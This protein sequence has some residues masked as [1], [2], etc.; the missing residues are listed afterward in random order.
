MAWGGPTK[1]SRTQAAGLQ[2][3]RQKERQ[4]EPEQT[5]S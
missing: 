5:L 4:A 2:S 1:H 3:A